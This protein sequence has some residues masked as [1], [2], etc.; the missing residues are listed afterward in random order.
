LRL[1]EKISEEKSTWKE[2]KQISG[3]IS[4]PSTEWVFH[5]LI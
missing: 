1:I 2:R 4:F 3:L 5:M